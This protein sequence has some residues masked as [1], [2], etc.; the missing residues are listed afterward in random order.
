[1][2][3]IHSWTLILARVLQGFGAAAVMSVNVALVRLIYPQRYL[4]R[5]MGINALIV[6]VSAAAGPSVAA[7]IL[8]VSSWPWLFAVNVPIG[9]AAFIC[10]M[11]FLPE[12]PPKVG[13]PKFDGYSAL[14]NA[15]TFGLLISAIS[16]FAQ[17]QNNL[18]LLGELVVMLIV[19]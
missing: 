2:C 8:S 14:L 5:G 7:A 6:A 17:R 16:G 1:R 18:L 13:K 15:L 3:P 11:K 12:N 19:G 4:G 10:G 9:I